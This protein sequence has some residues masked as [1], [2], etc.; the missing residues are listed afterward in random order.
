MYDLKNIH[1]SSGDTFSIYLFINNR[2]PVLISHFNTT[3]GEHRNSRLNLLMVNQVFT[4]LQQAKFSVT[5]RGGCKIFEYG[6]ILLPVDFYSEMSNV[7]Q[8][9]LK[10][11]CN[12]TDGFIEKFSFTFVVTKDE[13]EKT[14]SAYGSRTNQPKIPSTN[15]TSDIIHELQELAILN[16]IGK[17]ECVT[18]IIFDP[19]GLMIV[20]LSH[21]GTRQCRGINSLADVVT[22]LQNHNR[23]IDQPHQH[24]PV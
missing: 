10:F 15:Q 13:F 1:M 19:S 4:E 3:K 7:D 12:P 5:G 24:P 9:R 16:G 17:G 2:P 6:P 18:K 21:V 8:V 11:S 20:N 23:H 22:E 14:L